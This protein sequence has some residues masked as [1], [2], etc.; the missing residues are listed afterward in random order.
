MMLRASSEQK[1]G[2]ADVSVI[3]GEADGVSDGGHAGQ[4]GGQWIRGHLHLQGGEALGNRTVEVPRSLRK[5][6]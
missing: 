5:S 2:D 3:T 6:I 4:V 1:G